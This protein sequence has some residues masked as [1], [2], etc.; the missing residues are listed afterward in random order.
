MEPFELFESGE[1][2]DPRES[3]HRALFERSSWGVVVL[4][5]SGRIIDSNRAFRDMLGMSAGELLEMPIGECVHRDHEASVADGLKRLFAGETENLQLEVSFVRTSGELFWGTIDLFPY[6]DTVPA[7]GSSV[8]GSAEGRDGAVP[9]AVLIA[10]VQ[11]ITDRRSSQKSLRFTKFSVDTTTDPVFWVM[12]DAKIIYVNDAAG[13]ALGQ[14]REELLRMSFFD[15][16]LLH[17]AGKWPAFWEEL[18]AARSLTYETSTLTPS[19]SMLPLEVLAN[20]LDYDG[21]EYMC[22]F[23]R[24]I[25]DRKFVE[26]ELKRAQSAAE[27]ASREKSDF[28]ARMSHEIRTPMNAIIGMGDTLLETDLTPEQEKYVKTMTGAGDALLTLI[29]DIL[30]ISKIEAG[31]L[32]LET[33]DFDIRDLAEQTVEMLSIRS[34]SKNIGLTCAVS[35][36]VPEGLKG[37]PTRLRQIFI[38]LI[39]NAIKFTERG[40]VTLSISRD[41]GAAPDT[42]LISVTDT[43]IGIPPEKCATVFERFTQADTSHTRK[44]GGTGL[45]LSICKQL[46]LLM[47]GWIWAES[48]VGKGTSFKFTVPLPAAPD[49][50]RMDRASLAKRRAG[51]DSDLP[52]N[53]ILVVEDYEQNRVVVRAY[54]Q[55]TPHV[56]DFAE[57]G[58][59]AL[60]KIKS[61]ASYDLIF[62]DLQMPVMDGFTA[63][64]EI[65][66]WQSSAGAAPTP[67]IALSADALKD[68]IDKS[69]AAGCNAHATKPIKKEKFMGLIREYGRKTSSPLEGEAGR[70]V[71]EGRTSLAPLTPPSPPEGGEGV[72]PGDAGIQVRVDGELKDFVDQFVLETRDH[73]KEIVREL[74]TSDVA[75]I[76]KRGHKLKG[77]GGAFGFDPVTDLGKLI[78]EGAKRGDVDTI[79]KSARELSDYMD[80][81]RIV[82][83]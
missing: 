30:D 54:L 47:G 69:M 76:Q 74:E 12:S 32:E 6:R 21:L 67:I 10:T 77:S 65:R 35:P 41:V 64:R 83:E 5:E 34:R 58:A 39:G 38:N 15:I 51:A 37:D 29:N 19:G 4:G 82:Y 28:L 73:L 70:G 2:G 57:N 45:G 31:R 13:I 16:D 11:D 25:T 71:S 75:S 43:G 72:H 52:P 50:K 7:G 33:V 14:T 17:P 36:D 20:F 62:M 22:V 63:T 40:G 53:R 9:G 78:E 42:Y 55:K 1:S 24:D 68:D 18:R 3:W 79:R 23:A 8:H 81:V 48:E 49:F 56:L 26:E 80:R 61:G 44:Y 46:V 60:D 27:S 66:A 59:V